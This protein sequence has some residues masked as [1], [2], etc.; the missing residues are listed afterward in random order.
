MEEIMLKEDFEL[1]YAKTKG[2]IVEPRQRG[3]RI[4]PAGKIT[5]YSDIFVAIEGKNCCVT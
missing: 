2:T 3:V 5:A 1:E 4:Y